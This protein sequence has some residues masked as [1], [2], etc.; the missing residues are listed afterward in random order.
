MRHLSAPQG[1]AVPALPGRRDSWVLHCRRR[2]DTPVGFLQAYPV[3]ELAIKSLPALVALADKASSIAR[4][5]CAFFSESPLDGL[6]EE[7]EAF[8]PTKEPLEPGA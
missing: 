8:Q 3:N 4:S 7:A 5:W 1:L 2:H 6:R